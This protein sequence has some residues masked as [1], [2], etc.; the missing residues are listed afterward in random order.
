MTARFLAADHDER[1]RL[2]AAFD[3]DVRHIEPGV[4]SSRFAAFL[5]PYNTREEAARALLEA[6]AVLGATDVW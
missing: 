4:R 5:S 1:G 2:Y 6:G 3:P